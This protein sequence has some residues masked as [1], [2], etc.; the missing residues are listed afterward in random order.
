MEK[1][2]VS[3]EE[4]IE[5]CIP[6]EDCINEIYK[7][8][9]P[10]CDILKKILQHVC[11]NPNEYPEKKQNST[12]LLPKITAINLAPWYILRHAG[13]YKSGEHIL[14]SPNWNID[15]VHFLLDKLS[16]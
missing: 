16:K 5:P 14:Q 13:F 15:T 10:V 11:D 3:K 7:L 8:N 4:Y 6:L 1:E 2:E 12:K 9:Q